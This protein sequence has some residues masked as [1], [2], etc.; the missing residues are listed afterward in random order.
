M[1][2]EIKEQHQKTK[3]MTLKGKLSYFWYYYKIHTL[4]I[5]AGAALI[6]TFIYQLVNNKDYA[7]YAVIMN[8]D[9]NLIE[10]GQWCDEFAEYAGI[11]TDEFAAYLDTSFIYSNTNVN[12][13]SVSSMEKLLVMVQTGQI[14]VITADT[15]AF[16]NYAQNEFF[17]NLEESLPKDVLEKYKDYL[18]YTDAA[19]FD[20]RNNTQLSAEDRPNPS[21]FI[22]NH[23]DPSTME[24]PI[25]VGIFLPEGNKILETGC[26][27]YLSLGE[28]TYQ[29]YPSE[30]VLGIPVNCGHIDTV[31]KFLAFLET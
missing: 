2:G 9:T 27:D 29:G 14:D 10:D 23:H 12:Q 11:D 1:H 25:P 8:A 18:Y 17:I 6:G 13:Y 31:L 21:T 16:E 7:F 3:D 5:I 20:D 30:A 28:V 19:S 24:K 26:F 22:I 4:A 15:A